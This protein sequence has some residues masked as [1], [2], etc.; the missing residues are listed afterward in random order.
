MTIVA[1]FFGLA[2]FIAMSPRQSGRWF[3]KAYLGF[4]AQIRKEES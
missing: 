4:H 2:I 3:A 1:A